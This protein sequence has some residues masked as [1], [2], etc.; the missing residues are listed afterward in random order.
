MRRRIAQSMVLFAAMALPLSAAHAIEVVKTENSTLDINGRMQLVGFGQSVRDPERNDERA[1]MFVKQARLGISGNYDDY[2]Y[3]L[4]LAFAGE[5]EVKAPSPGVSLSL[6][7]LYFDIPAGIISNTFVRVGQHKVPYS[8]ERLLDSG[9][10]PYADRSLNNFGFQVGREA[11]ATVASSRGLFA[12]AIG[13][14]TGGGRDV[15]VR[16]LPEVLGFPLMV[17]RVGINNG[18]DE[19]V[20]ASKHAASSGVATAFFVNG[21]YMQ[22]SSVGHSTVFNVRMGDRPLLLNANWNP[23]LAQA[24]FSRGD[25]TQ[26]GG[27]AAIR[28]PVGAWSLSGELEG[29]F[30]TYANKYGRVTVTGGRAQVAAVRDALELGARY[31]VVFPDEQF[32]AGGKQVTGGQPMQEITPGVAYTLKGGWAKLVADLPI[33]IGAPVATEP[34]I[35]AYV[36]T[37]LTEQPDQTSVLKSG[38]AVAR[39]D[40]VEARLMLQATF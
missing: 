15:P 7:D 14:Y 19:D 27:D 2:R 4:Q 20:F 38:G 29:N 30:S 9:N 35:G 11:G 21:M 26:L 36:L 39:Q 8:R 10:L 16:M 5:E 18:Y 1:Y 22:D 24:P 3:K 33:L 34:G 12:G 17:A 28:V 25:F 31:A 6:Q 23:F 37:V 32:A 40:I 13:V